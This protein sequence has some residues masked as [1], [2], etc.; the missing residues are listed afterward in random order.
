M[1]I[2]VLS[3]QNEKSILRKYA[4][5]LSKIIQLLLHLLM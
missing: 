1:Y 4:T 2:G 3:D 5:Q